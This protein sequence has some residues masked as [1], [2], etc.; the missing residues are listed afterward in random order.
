M[1][2]IA[3]CVFFKCQSLFS[4][5]KHELQIF[6]QSDSS[7]EI[8]FSWNPVVTTNDFAI[9]SEFHDLDISQNMRW[10]EKNI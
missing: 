9:N 6:N 3:K 5:K 7:E 4:K 1:H 8:H 10:I 2:N